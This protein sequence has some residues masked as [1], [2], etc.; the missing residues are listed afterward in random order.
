MFL[1][2]GDG[3]G[4]GTEWRLPW[5]VVGESAWGWDDGVKG[6]DQGSLRLFSLVGREVRFDVQIVV[7]IQV[8]APSIAV[9][10]KP[11]F[12]NKEDTSDALL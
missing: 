3:R 7:E 8:R 12:L 6:E 4:V 9:E 5:W 2:G 11:C 1:N 10:L